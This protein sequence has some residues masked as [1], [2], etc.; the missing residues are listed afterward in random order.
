MTEHSRGFAVGIALILLS[1][2]AFPQAKEYEYQPI[3]RLMEE[4][5][6]KGGS[7]LES[8]LAKVQFLGI[9]VN[10]LDLQLAKAITWLQLAAEGRIDETRFRKEFSACIEAIRHTKPEYSAWLEAYDLFRQKRDLAAMEAVERLS[11]AYPDFPDGFIL[12]GM[13]LERTNA[14]K[15]E[16]AYRKAVSLGN[17]T[18]YAEELL[19]RLER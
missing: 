14:K 1:F 19:K 16:D 6:K 17:A 15:A 12:K 2:A 3:A 5:G 13:I 4:A 18:G 11:A 8:D 10:S 7:V 9:F